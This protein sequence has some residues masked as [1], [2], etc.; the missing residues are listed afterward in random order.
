MYTSESAATRTPPAAA[1]GAVARRVRMG[2][3]TPA[4]TAATSNVW[5]RANFKVHLRRSMSVDGISAAAEQE[6]RR[7]GVWL[8]HE[9]KERGHEFL[10]VEHAESR[11][12]GIPKGQMEFGETGFECAARELTEETG[13]VMAPIELRAGLQKTITR[14]S[15]TIYVVGCRRRLTTHIDKV[16]QHEITQARWLTF[17]ELK[18]ES[19]SNAT[20]Y[21]ARQVQKWLK[22]VHQQKKKKHPASTT[23]RTSTKNVKKITEPPSPLYTIAAPLS[24][25]RPPMQL[26]MLVETSA[27]RWDG[28]RWFIHPPPGFRQRVWL[29]T[30]LSTD[31]G[32]FRFH[33]GAPKMPHLPFGTPVHIATSS[34]MQHAPMI[35]VP[36]P[37]V[38]P[39]GVTFSSLS[40]QALRARLILPKPQPVGFQHLLRTS[41][42][43]FIPIGA[44]AT[45]TA[46]AVAV[47]APVQATTDLSHSENWKEKNEK[48]SI[49]RVFPSTQLQVCIPETGSTVSSCPVTTEGTTTGTGTA[50][51]TDA[52]NQSDSDSDS[53]LDSDA[54]ARDVD[55]SC[56]SSVFC[57]YCDSPDLSRMSTPDDTGNADLDEMMQHV[58][59]EEE[60]GGN[61]CSHVDF[62]QQLTPAVKVGATGVERRKRR[63][64]QNS[65]YN[66]VLNG[67]LAREAEALPP[68]NNAVK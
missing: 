10:C 45:A 23:Q 50:R 39:F 8:H 3:L 21:M 18:K 29:G 41:A 47:V 46:A 38:H 1:A 27:V 26:P 5:K 62:N 25:P 57:L 7:Y 51:M 22:H 66:A 11:F 2:P 20:K 61:L 52:S 14:W 16:Q 31:R 37:P 64:A 12:W 6:I 33:E 9:S 67:W 59:E 13:I 58:Q 4:A 53:D 40:Q 60:K 36:P 68:K 65:S 43:P 24:R 15:H 54:F 55:C 28:M 48:F 17:S 49:M 19:L 32:L 35:P 63:M 56:T 34:T 42:A 30:F 44:A